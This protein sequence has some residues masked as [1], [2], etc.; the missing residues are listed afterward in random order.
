MVSIITNESVK[1]FDKLEKSIIELNKSDSV[2]ELHW[3]P[4]Y[5]YV[6]S[7]TNPYVTLWKSTHS[8]KLNAVRQITAKLDVAVTFL[9]SEVGKI[10]KG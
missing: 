7:S 9:E 2:N 3:S 5:D 4:A 10:T 6:S 1:L 8:D